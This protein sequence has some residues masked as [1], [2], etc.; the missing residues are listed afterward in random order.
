MKINE[1]ELGFSMIELLIA[2]ILVGVLFVAIMAGLRQSLSTTAFVRAN[3]IALNLAKERI[4]F[5]KQ[6][7][8]N[9]SETRSSTSTWLGSPNPYTVTRNNVNF[10]VSTTILNSNLPS[11]ATINTT[12][13]IDASLFDIQTDT[14]NVIPIKVSVTWP[15]A[16][17]PVVL[18]TLIIQNYK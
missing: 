10:Y 7:E 9:A 12:N 8:G 17:K 16:T 14:S 13:P 18:E 2:L 6:Y 11:T 3:T 1:N 5:L 15:G 4:E